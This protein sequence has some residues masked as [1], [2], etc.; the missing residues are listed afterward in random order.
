MTVEEATTR[1]TDVEDDAGYAGV[2]E[3]AEEEPVYNLE[4]AIDLKE[5]G[6]S[7]WMVYMLALRM[8]RKNDPRFCPILVPATWKRLD[9]VTMIQAQWP[10][11]ST[12]QWEDAVKACT[13]DWEEVQKQ[14]PGNKEA[15]MAARTLPARIKEREESEKK[16]MMDQLK[17]LGN[18]FLGAFGLS[19]DNF[20]VNPNAGGE[21]YNIQFKQ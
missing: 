7:T 20:A 8:K 19:L 9:E 18:S 1:A 21:G 15:M 14:D 11:G 4:D 10:D 17:S 2:T 3:E 6:N 5:L 16:E 12:E 13:E